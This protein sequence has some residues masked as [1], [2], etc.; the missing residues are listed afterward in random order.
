MMVF[1]FLNVIRDDGPMAMFASRTIPSLVPSVTC[2]IAVAAATTLATG[3]Q[4]RFRITDL[5]LITAEP[6]HYMSMA[7]GINALGEVVG[8]SGR[9]EEEPYAF[10]WLPED[11]YG[12]TAGPLHSLTDLDQGLQEC[13][14][15]AHDINN[16]GEIAGQLGAGTTD[17]AARSWRYD[18]NWSSLDLSDPNR[19][20]RAYAVSNHDDPFVVG[21]H[22][23]TAEQEQQGYVCHANGD[24]L[25]FAYR[26][27]ITGGSVQ[28]TDLIPDPGSN[29]DT[30]AWDLTDYAADPHIVGVMSNCGGAAWPCPT[31]QLALFWWI[32]GEPQYF[33]GLDPY[34]PQSP[35]RTEARGISLV[36]GMIEVAGI[37]WDWDQGDVCYR[38]A[39][40]WPG[41]Q[42][43]CDELPD[44][45]G[46]HT[47]STAHAICRQGSVV[48]VVGWEGDEDFVNHCD[49]ILWEKEDGGN[50]QPI[51]LDTAI[52][53][54]SH[55]DW[56]LYQAQD[57]NADGWIVGA[58]WNE[59]FSQ[60]HAFLL[61]PINHDCP[62]DVN[63]DGTVD[64]ADLLELLGA[65][66]TCRTGHICRTDINLD[67]VTNTA[68]L[69]LLQGNWGPCDGD[70]GSQ[71]P[72]EILAQWL[73]AGG[74]EALLSDD[75]TAE[76]V[77]ACLDKPTPAEAIAA[78]YELLFD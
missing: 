52:P 67:C 16:R 63:G 66:G 9:G 13:I 39:A 54:C 74:E 62:W 38:H 76:E 78:L 37:A 46:G 1:R 55:E 2:V 71:V 4:P 17:P 59:Q 40:Y 35:W 18:D 50:W 27:Q 77:G 58:G 68:D 43:L 64:T 48:R 75:I 14:S 45:D 29:R 56:N 28:R 34:C 73:A 24:P 60:I 3:Q 25:K 51:V 65:W 41:P 72:E 69:L 8:W 7:L 49:P 42:T 6:G 53:T 22:E 20:S 23:A 12:L 31:E 15:E 61:T 11:N 47:P 30:V 36:G 19:G 32:Q 44:P 57:V 70:G 21:W 26:A 10:I 33:F 5:G